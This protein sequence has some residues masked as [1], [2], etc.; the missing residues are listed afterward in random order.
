MKKSLKIKR[1]AELL[2]EEYKLSRQNFAK[3]YFDF[4]LL[5]GPSVRY[6]FGG[7]MKLNACILFL[8][9]MVYL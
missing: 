2:I 3:F 8:A 6:H 7:S 4:K 5:K 1:I 9:H